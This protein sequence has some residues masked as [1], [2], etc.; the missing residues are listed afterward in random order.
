[1]LRGTLVEWSSSSDSSNSLIQIH[2]DCHTSLPFIDMQLEILWY[3]CS[4]ICMEG[5]VIVQRLRSYNC[6]LQFGRVLRSLC[7]KILLVH[8][9]LDYFLIVKVLSLSSLVSVRSSRC[10]QIVANESSSASVLNFMFVVI[11]VV[12]RTTSCESV[13]ETSSRVRLLTIINHYFNVFEI[14]FRP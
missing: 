4:K 5:D 7:L 14:C 13:I 12:I 2:L 3:Q 1:M 6:S 8:D 10:D 11:R 9:G